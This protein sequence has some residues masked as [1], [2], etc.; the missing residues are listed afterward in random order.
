MKVYSLYILYTQTWETM[1]MN[2]QERK[3]KQ[4]ASWL[5]VYGSKMVDFGQIHD[6]ILIKIN[7][8]KIDRQTDYFSKIQTISVK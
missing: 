6:K 3:N 5:N 8:D 2:I 7:I 4:I 1:K